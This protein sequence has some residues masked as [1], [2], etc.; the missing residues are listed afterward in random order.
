M[1]CKSNK[2][3]KLC[4][5]RTG[6]VG[7]YLHDLY[8]HSGLQK[9][10]KYVR[11]DPYVMKWSNFSPELKDLA[12]IEAV[13]MSNYLVLQMASSSKQQ[14]KEHNHLE[15]YSVFVSTWSTT[16]A[17]RFCKM[18]DDDFGFCQGA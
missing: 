4:H 16:L 12:A 15:A 14:K 9:T 8:D 7:S 13:N 11:H 1:L 6:A 17:S 10:S 2:V 5:E 3:H 18:T